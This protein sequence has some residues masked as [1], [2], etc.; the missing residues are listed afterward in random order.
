M[1]EIEGVSTRQSMARSGSFQRMAAVAGLVPEGGAF[2]EDFGVVAED[3]EAVG[4]A[5]GDPE[6]V[7]VVRSQL[8]AGPLAECGGA[9]ADV[10]GDVEDGAAGAPDEFSL[11]LLELVVEAADDAFLGVGMVVLGEVVG[12][13]VGAE[14]GRHGRFP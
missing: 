12:E 7:A 5:G 3:A 4:E 6:H 9:S 11:G 10:D 1:G 14:D 2:V 13:A 8:G